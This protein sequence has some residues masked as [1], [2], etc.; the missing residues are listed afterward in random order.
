MAINRKQVSKKLFK[1]LSALRTTLT[2]DERAVL[3]EIVTGRATQVAAHKLTNKSVNK[4]MGRATHKSTQV[5][6]HKLTHKSVNKAMGRAT[7][8]STQVAAH[9]LLTKSPKKQLPRLLAALPPRLHFELPSTPRPKSIR[10]K[11]RLLSEL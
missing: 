4:A 10:S 6:A 2:K 11:N 5:A 3:D 1:K 7:H 8:K 9:K